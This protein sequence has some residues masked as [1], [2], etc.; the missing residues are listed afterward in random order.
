[1]S[2]HKSHLHYIFAD[3]NLLLVLYEDVDE[4]VVFL[5][6]GVQDDARR[7]LSRLFSDGCPYCSTLWEARMTSSL[8]SCS[9]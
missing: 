1:M 9:Q 2:K 3:D 8:A 7:L 4:L 6:H 5:V